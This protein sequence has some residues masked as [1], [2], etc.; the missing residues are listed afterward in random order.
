MEDQDKAKTFIYAGFFLFFS[1]TA[2]NLLKIEPAHTLYYIFAWWS[3]IFFVDGVIYTIRKESL[4]ISRTAQFFRLLPWS[5][6]IWF[7]FELLNLRLQNWH[8]MYIPSSD[9]LR[10]SGYILAYATV[11][12]GL[13]ETAELIETLGLF[14]K[15]KIKPLKITPKLLRGSMIIGAAF[16][17]LP[18]LWPKYFFPLIWGGFI[19]LIETL[20]SRLGLSSFLKDWAQ[21]NIKKFYTLLLSG[22]ICGGL[23][24]FWNF[25][26]GAKWEYTVPFVGNLKIF[27]MPILGY[28]GFPPFAISCYVMYSFISYIWRG[29]NHEFESRKN[30]KI[31][32]KPLLTV[33]AYIIVIALSAI[34]IAAIDK[35]TVWLYIAHL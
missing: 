32:N 34:T 17:A 28:I 7:V 11:L 12:P 24:E 27:E 19:F 9:Y 18:M 23:W 15:L 10:W 20:N 25:F 33:G 3:Y 29:K 35:Y 16:I 30:L 22:F 31:P 26:S 5:A 2:L 1:I 14:K 13:F 6:F 4:I 8:Y 21:G